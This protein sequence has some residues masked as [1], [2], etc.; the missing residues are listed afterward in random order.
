MCVEYPEPARG[1]YWL[2]VRGVVAEARSG[3]SVELEIVSSETGS[4]VLPYGMENGTDLNAK[5]FDIIDRP[6]ISKGT[7]AVGCIVL[8]E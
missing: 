6:G 7:M 1:A 5:M 8:I 2:D 3:D 4:L